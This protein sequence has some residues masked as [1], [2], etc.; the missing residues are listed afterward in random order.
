MGLGAVL[1]Q[2]GKIISYAS[3][4]LTDVEQRY[5]QTDREFLAVVY[6]VEH[7]HLYL[8][9]SKFTVTTDHK[10]LLGIISCSK[11]ATARI[12]RLRLCLM[13]Y[14]FELQYRPGQDEQNPADY[15]SRYSEL[16]KPTRDNASEAYVH[17]VC[18]NAI[19]KS[20]QA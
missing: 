11:P 19:P 14:E 4:A 5:S 7:F 6:G 12:E 8:F 10:P 9:G 17:Y 3:R 18:K 13:P 16:S 15:L 2:Q 1:A 20:Y